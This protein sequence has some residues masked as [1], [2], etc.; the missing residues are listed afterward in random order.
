MLQ[1]PTVPKRPL[2]YCG[3]VISVGLFAAGAPAFAADPTGD[4]A[5]ENAVAH[6]RIADCGG[7]MWG[8]VSWE[9]TPGGVDKNNPDASKRSRPTLGMVTLFDM[10]KS[11]KADEWKGK[12]YDA[13]DSGKMYDATIKPKGADELEIEGCLVWPLCGSQT[14]TRVSPPIPSSPTNATA[15]NANAAAKG[16]ATTGAKAAPAPAPSTMA[17]A[18][19]APAAKSGPAGQKGAA[20][21]QTADIGDICLLPEINKVTH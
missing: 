14:W 10:K 6:I 1:R 8:A 17:K 4:W 13:R 18:T 21:A 5:V 7:S 11:A 3:I 12:V 9:K 16:A 15:K 2:T 20:G 19:P